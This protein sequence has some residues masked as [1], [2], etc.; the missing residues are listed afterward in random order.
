MWELWPYLSAGASLYIPDELT[1][2]VPARLLP[3]LRTHGITLCFLP[4]PLAEALLAEPDLD[5]LA[6]RT[7]LTGG[8]SCTR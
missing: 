7:L 8:M 4:T 6:L 2:A 1:R 5:G 3:W